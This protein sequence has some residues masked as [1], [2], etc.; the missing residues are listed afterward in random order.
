MKR[1]LSPFRQEE[2]AR[3]AARALARQEERRQL[4]LKRLGEWP[5]GMP[6]TA[7]IGIGSMVSLVKAGLAERLA[8]TDRLG[9]ERFAL[10]DAGRAALEGVA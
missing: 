9:E 6:V 2:L 1:S 4:A 8:A 10:T 3:R 5:Q 7:D